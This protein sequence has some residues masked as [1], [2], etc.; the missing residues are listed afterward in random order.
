MATDYPVL[1]QAT[2]TN[3]KTGNIPTLSIGGNE[4]TCRASCEYSG[5]PHYEGKDG[6][7]CY[8]WFGRVSQGFRSMVR[9]SISKPARYTLEHATE[10]CVRSA[11]YA[12]LTAIGD[13]SI[14]PE[15][16]ALAIVSA[17]VA[18]RLRPLGYVAGWRKAPW[19]AGILRASCFSDSD[20]AEALAAGWRVARIC[21]EDETPEYGTVCPQARGAGV[22]CNTCGLCAGS[23]GP[24]VIW[25]PFHGG[26]IAQNMRRK[27]QRLQEEA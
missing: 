6:C 2:T 24:A 19:F 13:A 4:E 18:A 27:H 8:A 1:W 9:G 10:N 22:T 20:E 11:R 25:F 26:A 21:G 5:C 16:Q 15:G 7:P 17:L 12:R 23:C 14:L 3:K